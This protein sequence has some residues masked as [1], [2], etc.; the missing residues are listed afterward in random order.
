MHARC[1]AFNLN[2]TVYITWTKKMKISHLA[3]MELNKLHGIKNV[4]YAGAKLLVGPGNFPPQIMLKPNTVN[5]IIG[6]RIKLER[7]PSF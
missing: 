6:G 7:V 2:L 4:K 1:L 5:V 3:C